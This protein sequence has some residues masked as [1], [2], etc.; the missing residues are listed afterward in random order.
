MEDILVNAMVI[1]ND[2]IDNIL[3]NVDEDQHRK[4]TIAKIPDYNANLAVLLA[5]N[6][7]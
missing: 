2:C 6:C 1:A 3:S 5:L 7:A 4:N